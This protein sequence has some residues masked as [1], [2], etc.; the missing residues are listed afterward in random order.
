MSF[1]VYDSMESCIIGTAVM[2]NSA[3]SWLVDWPT[4]QLIYWPTCLLVDL[5]TNWLADSVKKRQ[6]EGCDWHDSSNP[7]QNILEILVVQDL[8][9]FNS[10]WY[11]WLLRNRMYGHTIYSTELFEAIANL[12]TQYTD[13][14]SQPIPL[15]P[16]LSQSRWFP[17]SANPADSRSQFTELLLKQ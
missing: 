2:T 3:A 14:R 6:A 4:G 12:Y 11:H 1:C 15:I 17:L 13:S 8:L 16:A 7:R 10:V 9:V 5:S